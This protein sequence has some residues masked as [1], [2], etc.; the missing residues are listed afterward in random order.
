MQQQ[1]PVGARVPVLTTALAVCRVCFP[2]QDVEALRHV[3]ELLNEYVDTFS[4]RW[5]VHQ[6]CAAGLPRR[7]L[8]YLSAHGRDSE[9]GPESPVHRITLSAVR[10]GDL[11]VLQW[12]NEHH[13]D[14]TTWGAGYR[15]HLM[16]EAVDFGQLAILEWLHASRRE[17][18]TTWTMAMAAGKGRVDIVQWLHE[19]C[20]GGCTSFA[21]NQA[22]R[23]GHLE[24]VRFLHENRLE[25]C[26]TKAMDSACANGHLAV[27]KFLHEN[28][29][30]GC[31]SAAICRAAEGGHLETV[32][33]LC[34]NRSEGHP[35]AALCKAAKHGHAAL[36]EWLSGVVLGQRTGDALIREAVQEAL[37]ARQIGVLVLLEQKLRLD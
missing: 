34:A 37:K 24:V 2:L 32:Q 10:G 20:G 22:A 31:T 14:S 7:A 30:E 15:V 36:V 11:H 29:R 8:D 18:C 1:P 35:G 16:E 27:V 4:S 5:S 33:W 6:A 25:G 3:V 28:R 12:M 17:V 26:T 19:H 9:W 23:N 13:P 21:M